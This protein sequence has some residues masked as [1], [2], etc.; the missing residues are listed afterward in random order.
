MEVDVLMTCQPAIAFGFV[1]VEVV[2]YDVDLAAGMVGY[3][4]IHE[5]EKLHATAAPIV[6]AF[7][8]SGGHFQSRK[9]V[10]C[11]L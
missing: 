2:E 11:R 9:Q 6:I 10:P 5:V 3:D 8:Q 7:H 1:S 4:A